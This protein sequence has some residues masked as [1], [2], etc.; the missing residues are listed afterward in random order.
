MTRQ[1]ATS[2]RDELLKQAKTGNESVDA[3]LALLRQIVEAEQAR[4]RRLALWTK[5]VWVLGGSTIILFGIAVPVYM[6]LSIAGDAG[7]PPR[8][9][10]ILGPVVATLFFLS[11]PVFLMCVVAGTVLLVM[12]VLARRT[13]SQHQIR[14][15]LAAIDAQ[16]R[17]L[18]A[19]RP[20]NLNT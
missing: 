8:L 6:W 1:E 9:A 14:A 3:E 4:A 2:L 10:Q 5:R 15:S 11:I 17:V 16:L 13:A 7:A 19:A 12:T 20:K 18:S